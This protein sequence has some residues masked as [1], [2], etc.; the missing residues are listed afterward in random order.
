MRWRFSPRQAIR[1]DVYALIYAFMTEEPSLT[2]I[3][4]EA[5]AIRDALVEARSRAH[6][7]RTL[8]Q[9]LGHTDIYETHN[10]VANAA[11]FFGRGQFINQLVLKISRGENFGIFGLRRSARRR[12]C[13][14]YVSSRATIR[15]LCRS[16]GRRLATRR[17]GLCAP[18]ESPRPRPGIKHPDVPV[19]P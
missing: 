11:T 1:H 3:P 8:H 6:L 9:W 14:G 16:A 7:E 17:R 10:P 18:V 15:G 13:M 19:P 12:W 4:I 2:V 5:Q